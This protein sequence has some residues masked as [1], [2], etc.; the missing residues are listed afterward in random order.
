MAKTM[1]NSL[2]VRKT[3]KKSS[4]GSYR[5]K[6]KPNSPI[7]LAKARMNAASQFGKDLGES[8]LQFDKEGTFDFDNSESLLYDNFGQTS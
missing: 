7:V 1:K 2:K 6:R 3:A 8:P 5:E 4:H